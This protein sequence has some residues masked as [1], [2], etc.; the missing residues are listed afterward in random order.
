MVYKVIGLMSGSSLDGLDIAY[1]HL[2]ETGGKWTYELVGADCYSYPEKWKSALMKAISLPARDY[3]ELHCSYGHFLGKAV[4]KFIDEN[5]IHHQV[6]LV[7]SHGHTTF[8]EP[9]KHFTHQLGEGSAI[10]AETGLA[11]VSD[12]RAMDV[13]LSGQGAPIVPMGEKLLFDQYEMLLN[14]GGIGNLSIKEK[15]A[16]IAFDVCPVNRVLNMLA[17]QSGLEYDENGILA[18]QGIIYEKLLNEL[19]EIPYYHLSAPKSLSNEFG[20][21]ILFPLLMKFDLPLN[22]LLATFVEHIAMQIYLSV[23]SFHKQGSLMITGGGA[24]NDFMV[25]RIRHWLLSLNVNLVIPDPAIIKFKEAIIMAMLG[26]LRWREEN[27]TLSSVTGAQRNS[28]GGAI[29]LGT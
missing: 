23:S 29:W 10:A 28:I 12:L 2:H 17:I 27:T 22:D 5:Q 4:R 6:H 16:F 13:A 26:V 14:L 7:C 8:H 3:Y 21:G 11:V 18:S 19:N 25:G 20:T 9:G 1:V 15:E 24:F